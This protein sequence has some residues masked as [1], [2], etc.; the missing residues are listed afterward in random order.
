M[1]LSIGGQNGQRPWYEWAHNVCISLCI[2]RVGT[3]NNDNFFVE[4]ITGASATV[5]LTHNLS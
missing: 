3:S 1:E 4:F 5:I 2:S